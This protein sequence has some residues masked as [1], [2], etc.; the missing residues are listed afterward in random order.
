LPIS[1]LEAIAHDVA[2]AIEKKIGELPPQSPSRH[3]A[4]PDHRE[5]VHSSHLARSRYRVLK[6]EQWSGAIRHRAITFG[7]ERCLPGRQNLAHEL[8]N[9]CSLPEHGVHSV[10][11][12]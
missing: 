11:T 5:Q 7:A 1:T 12:A 8:A 3:S 9:M 2:E 10:S 4:N 6:A